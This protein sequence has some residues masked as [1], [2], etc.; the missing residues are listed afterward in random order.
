MSNSV[1]FSKYQGTGNDFIMIDNR[2]G[3]QPEL[4]YDQIQ[5]M[6]HRQFG[7]GAD[8][9]IILKEKEGYDFE[10]DFYNSDGRP[11]TMCGNGGRCIVAFAHDLGIFDKEVRFWAPDGE[12]EAIYYSKDQI[13]LKMQDV[14]GIQQH[15]LGLFANTG[16]PHLIIE[17]Q[18]GL[19]IDFKAAG[20][21]IRYNETYKPQGGTNV[22]FVWHKPE[23]LKIKTYERGVENLTFSCGTGTVAAVLCANHTKNYPSPL[24][25]ETDG[26][27]LTVHFERK[28]EGK[29]TNIWLEGPAM[30]TFSGEYM[31]S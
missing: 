16:S 21:E 10:M 8:G 25:V 20:S 14:N 29:Y 2:N 12:H 26:G 22:N 6:C 3:K 30:K 27:M 19:D 17:Q 9:M 24:K 31:L 5:Q 7:I 15:N 4:T 13:K 23:G 28:A 11:G 18:N 1:Y